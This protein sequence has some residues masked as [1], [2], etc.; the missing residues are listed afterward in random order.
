MSDLA[1]H[2]AQQIRTAETEAGRVYQAVIGLVTDNKDPQKLGRVR[3]KVPIL[4]EDDTTDW[5]PIV[6]FGASKNR[7]W[8]FIP[9]VDDEVLVMFEHGDVHRPLVIGALWNGMDP[10]PDDNRDGKNDRRVIKSRAGSRVL[11]D[12]GDSSKVV[13]EDGSGKG[14]ITL[15]SSNNKITIEALDGDVCLQAPTGKIQI[16]ATSVQVRATQNLQVHAGSDIQ[17]GSSQSITISGQTDG[18]SGSQLN[19]NCGNAQAPVAPSA[20]PQD[21]DDPYGS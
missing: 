4:S 6:M 10:P 19:Q 3:V 18:F 2:F 5:A 9:E 8:F 14:R 20:D 12:D 7:G 11:F 21:V 13:I 15:D 17:I 1:N 16:V